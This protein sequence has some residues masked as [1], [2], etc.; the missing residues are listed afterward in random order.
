MV[1]DTRSLGLQSC[2]ISKLVL[3]SFSVF[4][5]A[6][7]SGM[8][9]LKDSRSHAAC[10]ADGAENSHPAPVTQTA[11]CRA[12]PAGKPHLE[13][14]GFRRCL[15]SADRYKQSSFAALNS[16]KGGRKAS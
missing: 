6:I 14:A 12:V 9:G 10:S 5:P 1:R 3:C 4:P 8:T 16:V 13:E 11:W 15:V 2:S 7:C